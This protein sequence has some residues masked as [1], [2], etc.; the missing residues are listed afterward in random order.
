[1]NQW[2]PV[3]S[4]ANLDFSAFPI[5][6]KNYCQKYSA[7]L[8]F[9]VDEI[10]VRFCNRY[11]QVPMIIQRAA[12]NINGEPQ[13]EIL[14]HEEKKIVVPP[15]TNLWSDPIPLTCGK[16]DQIHVELQFGQEQQ[17]FSACTFLENDQMQVSGRKETG[18]ESVFESEFFEKEPLHRC[19]IGFDQI[20]GY[21]KEDVLVVTAFGD[22]ITHMSRWTA[23]LSEKMR[24]CPDKNM[25]LVNCGICGNRILHDA[26][27]GSGHGGWFGKKGLERFEKGVF[28]NDFTSDCVILLEGINDILHP[29]IGEAPPEEAVSAEQIVAGLEKC[30]EISHKYSCRVLAATLLPFRGCKDHWRPWHEEKRCN[31]NRMLWKSSSFDGILDFDRWSRDS[32]DPTRLDPTGGSEDALH[33]GKM[34]G[35]QISDQIDLNILSKGM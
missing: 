14:V 15:D 24:R 25:V 5:R 18:R 8:P 23:P 12:V 30:A 28:Q 27:R 3:W 1:M 19:V 33:P 29:A 16:S 9:D 32:Q 34:G 35:I 2:Y 20:A 10:R 11:N 17:L 26:S 13:M 7:Y 4:Y 31:V 22:S 6:V 21:T